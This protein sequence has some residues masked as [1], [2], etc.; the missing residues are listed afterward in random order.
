MKDY[1]CCESGVW[2]SSPYLPLNL[3][4][5]LKLPFKQRLLTK[6]ISF[7]NSLSKGTATKTKVNNNSF[8]V[9]CFSLLKY[10]L[11]HTLRNQKKENLKGAGSIGDD[12]V[13]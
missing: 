12:R 7:E 8:E 3:I 9:V 13:M 11:W 5:N 4:V 2:G 10:K 6:A 1:V